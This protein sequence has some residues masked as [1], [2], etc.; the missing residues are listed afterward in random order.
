MNEYGVETSG[1]VFSLQF[2]SLSICLKLRMPHICFFE[3]M[4]EYEVVGIS[5]VAKSAVC[6]LGSMQLS[7]GS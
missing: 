1:W 2:E 4:E 7:L 6:T 5:H 3:L